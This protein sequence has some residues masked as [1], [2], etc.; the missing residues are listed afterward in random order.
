[1]EDS[2]LPALRVLPAFRVGGE[3][4]V[5]TVQSALRVNGG[6]KEL[7]LLLGLSGDGVRFEEEWAVG[8]MEAL[9]TPIK[10][11]GAWMKQTLKTLLRVGSP[12]DG[13]GPQ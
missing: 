13:A 5:Q 2:V 3:G 6:G 7:A 11:H 4:M 9:F 10:I 8:K 1:M 12:R